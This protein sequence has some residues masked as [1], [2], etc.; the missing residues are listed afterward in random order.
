M[1]NLLA[2]FTLAQANPATPPQEILRPQEVRPLP[3]NLNT[4]PVFN[5]NSPELVLGEGI[6]LSTFPPTDK[7]NPEAHLNFPFEGRFDMFAHHVAKAD[8][9]DNLRTLYI[10]ILLHNPGDTTATVDILPAASYLSQPD[11]PFIELPAQVPNNQEDVYAG[12]GSRVM[13]DLLRDRD[14]DLFPSQ[15]IIPP[16]E[17]RMVMNLPIP[18]ATLDP[19]INGRSTYLKLRSDNPVYAASLAKFAP[20][21]DQGEERPPTLSEWETLLATGNLSTPRDNPPTPLDAAGSFRYGRVAGVSQGTKWQA[22]LTD[23]N[24]Q[25]LAIPEPGEAISYGIS[26]LHRGRLGTDQ[27]QTAPMLVRYPDTAYAAHGNY[28][29]HYSLNL[30][31]YNPTDETQQV[32]VAIETPIKQ[33]TLTDGLRFLNPLPTQTFFRGTVQVRYRDD[34]GFPR[35]RYFH[36][37]QKRGQAGEPLITL[38]LDPQSQRL[39][40]VDLLYPPDATPPQV[41]TVKTVESL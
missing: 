4:I 11:A 14:S 28:G 25:N 8:P 19:P 22:D 38:N 18:V 29:V 7:A 39:V 32:T 31:L 36:L 26:T 1:L 17:S 16:G 37:V 34:T 5:S 20:L 21:T 40:S 9:P 13:S 41:L 30:P 24:R 33:D 35:T 15:V 23:Q 3:G 12:P 27:I 6:L 10:G 2:A